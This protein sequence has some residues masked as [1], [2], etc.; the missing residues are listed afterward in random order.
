MI[1]GLIGNGSHKVWNDSENT[2]YQNVWDAVQAIFRRE[3]EK[4]KY[5]DEF[6]V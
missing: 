2:K 1:P 6:G 3:K 5:L 4:K